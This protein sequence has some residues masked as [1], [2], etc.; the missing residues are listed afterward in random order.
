MGS[1]RGTFLIA[2]KLILSKGQQIYIGDKMAFQILEINE[3]KG[4]LIIGLDK[5]IED[6]KTIILKKE[7][8]WTIGRDL[9][10]NN[11]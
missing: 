10:N 8:S 9:K 11:Y 1:K 2:K 6:K 7:E 5:D 4:E 3:R